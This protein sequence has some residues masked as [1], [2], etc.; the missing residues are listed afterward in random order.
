MELK[1]RLY[2][3]CLL[4]IATT[5]FFI[6]LNNKKFT[7]HGMICIRLVHKKSNI[8]ITLRVKSHFA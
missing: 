3:Y 8:Q 7:E 4:N 2:A 6:P 1:M 5:Q